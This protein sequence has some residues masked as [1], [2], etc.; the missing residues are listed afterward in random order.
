MTKHALRRHILRCEGWIRW[1]VDE[2]GAL[3]LQKDNQDNVNQQFSDNKNADQNHRQD[4]I[5]GQDDRQPIFEAPDDHEDA[6]KCKEI[7]VL[8]MKDGIPKTPK[9]RSNENIEFD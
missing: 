2:D 6:E 5:G 3:Y 8:P 7:E 4:N 1:C 9:P